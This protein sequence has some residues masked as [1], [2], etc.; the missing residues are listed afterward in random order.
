M[1][2]RIKYVRTKNREIYEKLN[3]LHLSQ[4]VVLTDVPAVQIQRILRSINKDKKVLDMV[5]LGRYIVVKKV[6]PFNF[7]VYHK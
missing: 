6:N 7:N 1:A 4:E 3:M 5:D 2:K